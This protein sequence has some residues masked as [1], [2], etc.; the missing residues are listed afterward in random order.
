MRDCEFANG[1]ELIEVWM[2]VSEK[3]IEEERKSLL[4]GTPQFSALV[5]EGGVALTKPPLPSHMVYLEPLQ[6]LTGPRFKCN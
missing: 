4:R 1:G 2:V 3:E 6:L 5:G